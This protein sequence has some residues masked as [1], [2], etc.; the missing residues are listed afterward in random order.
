MQNPQMWKAKSMFEGGDRVQN[1]D[2]E[3]T[4]VNTHSSGFILNTG[5]K[6]TQWRKGSLFNKH[7]W[8]I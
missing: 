3:N 1:K 6:N 8:V 2:T 4:K 7:F 5:A